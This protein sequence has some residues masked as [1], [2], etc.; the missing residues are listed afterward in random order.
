MVHFHNIP[1][2]LPKRCTM[3]ILGIYQVYQQLFHTR[4]FSRPGQQVSANVHTCVGD[5][6]GIIPHA[7]RATRPGEKADSKR[8]S[9]KTTSPGSPSGLIS[10]TEIYQDLQE[11]Y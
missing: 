4:F 2:I 10:C 9:L 3:Y 11:S 7:T 8:L 5:Q 1:G 6:E